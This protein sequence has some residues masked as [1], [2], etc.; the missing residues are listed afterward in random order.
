MVNNSEAPLSTRRRNGLNNNPTS[1]GG[2]AGGDE[3][4][5]MI[6]MIDNEDSVEYLVNEFIINIC[7][8]L[9]FPFA[10]DANEDIISRIYK[11]IKDFNFFNKIIGACMSNSALV[12][13]EIPISLIARLVLTDEDLVQLMIDQLTNSNQ[14]MNKIINIFKTCLIKMNSL[15]LVL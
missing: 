14:V 13:N 1:A 3:L 2:S 12:S 7:Q 11:I 10:I 4:E 6:A 5:G 9:C 15:I 8:I